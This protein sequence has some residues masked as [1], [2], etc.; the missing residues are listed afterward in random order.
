V[1]PSVVRAV[2]SNELRLLFRDTRALFMAVL[3]PVFLLP[4]MLLASGWAE[5]RRAERSETRMYRTLVT[6]P[7][8][9]W[10]SSLIAEAGDGRFEL[11][12]AS[13]T[14][15]GASGALAEDRA[16]LWVEALDPST[17]E[18]EVVAAADSTVR[19]DPVTSEA[20]DASTAADSPEWFGTPVLRLHFRSDRPVSDEA[21]STLSAALES[22]RS[23]ARDA[24]LGEV[25]GRIGAAGFLPVRTESV[26]SEQE[27][28][29]AQL[30]RLLTALLLGLV[31][32]GGSAVATDTLAGEKERGTLATLLTTA[33][34]RPQLVAGKLIAVMAVALGIAAIQ[35]LN[36]WLLVGTGLLPVGEA[37]SVPV[38]PLMAAGLLLLL[39][40]VIAL[41]AG[42]L[43]LTSAH[44]RSYKEAQLLLTP[45]LLG[46]IVPALAPILPDLPLRSAVLLV[47]IANLSLG[48]RDL[49]GG[50]PDV[51]ALI[52]AW[53]VTGGAALWVLRRSVNAI[54]DEDRVTGDRPRAEFLGGAALFPMRVWRWFAVFWAVKVLLELNVAFDDVR[55]MVLFHVGLV[56]T[57]FPLLVVRHFRLDPVEALSL[58]LP[59]PAAWLAVLIGAPCGLVVAQAFFRLASLVLPVPTEALESFGQGLLP[60]G[61]PGWQIILLFSLVPGIAEELTFRGVLLHGLRRRFSPVVL[62]LVVGLVFGFFHFQLFRI[63]VTALLGVLLTVVTMASGSVY[64]AMLW[65]TL[66]NGLAVWLGLRAETADGTAPEAAFLESGAAVAIALAG[67]A[68]ALT[69]L[70]RIRKGPVLPSSKEGGTRPPDLHFGRG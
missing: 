63:P 16:D 66:N 20:T 47:P 45:V 28:R 15:E 11:L 69:L 34:P 22:R 2:V 54:L 9:E 1:I 43:L 8:A 50:Q 4:V 56:F 31:L 41:A 13:T 62:A 64:P 37:F 21:Q 68:F 65:H 32:I 42:T 5:D 30:G 44:A 12:P 23:A 60:E 29:G 10:A 7:E 40:P 19:P 18:A 6:G 33:A 61:V 36:L 49:L 70:F 53:L 57:A 46:M 27:V 58:R 3:L 17:W 67:L 35:L 51:L 14:G 59:H 38:S 48:V 52:G 24:L 25:G 26:A 55:V 39:L